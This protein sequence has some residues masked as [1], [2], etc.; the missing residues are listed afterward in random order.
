[1][2]PGSSQ[3]P[4]RSTAAES[5][6]GRSSVICVM[7]PS[8]TWTHASGSTPSG[9]TTRP[10][11]RSCVG[12]SMR[13]V[14]V[15]AASALRDA[16]SSLTRRQVCDERDAVTAEPGTAEL[17]RGAGGVEVLTADDQHRRAHVHPQG[18]RLARGRRRRL[19]PFLAGAQ[20]GVVDLG[21]NRVQ[22]TVAADL[23]GQTRKASGRQPGRLD[24]DGEGVGEA[25]S[26]DLVDGGTG[27][28]AELLR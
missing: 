13:S 6:S 5:R 19:D 2:Y 8:V 21:E 11:P 4:C 22:R 1:M 27:G 20:A 14:T 7:R 23:A 18:P 15:I 17:D 9:V 12:A 26:L 25:E 16:R 3:A 10:P 24:C 28:Q